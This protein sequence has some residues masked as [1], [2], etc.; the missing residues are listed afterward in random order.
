MSKDEYEKRLKEEFAKGYMA[1]YLSYRP[2]EFPTTSMKWN[3]YREIW[4]YPGTYIETDRVTHPIAEW[5]LNITTASG[6]NTNPDREVFISNKG[7]FVVASDQ[8]EID[9]SRWNYAP[10]VTQTR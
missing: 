5:E 10:T 4:E 8:T 1:G 3:P 6:L 2:M 9:A 7:G